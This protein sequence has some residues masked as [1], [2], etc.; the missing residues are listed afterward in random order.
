MNAKQKLIVVASTATMALTG[1]T[2][3][4][5][6]MG[7]TAGASQ[8]PAAPPAVVAQAPS[9]TAASPTQASTPSDPAEAPGT[10][11]AD[12]TEAPDATDAPEAPGTEAP[13]KAEPGDAN[14]P[15]G[16]HADPP[17]NVDHQFQ[18]VE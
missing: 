10:E 6:S 8:Q 1:L 12:A 7:G 13:D 5:V 3:G 15:G 14:L 4:L 2:A 17:G 18:G 16:G 9:T 11:T